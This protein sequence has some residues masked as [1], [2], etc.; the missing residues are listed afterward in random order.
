M[1]SADAILVDRLIPATFLEDL[2]VSSAGKLVQW[3][4]SEEPHWTQEEVNRWLVATAKT[5]RTVARL[6]GGDPFVFGR[7]DSEIE[8]LASH[9]IPWEVIPGASSAT[10][11]LGSAGLP[12]TRHGQRRSF[13]VATARVEGG[14]VSTSFPPRRLAGDSDGGDGFGPS[15]GAAIGRWLAVRHARGGC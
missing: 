13:A 2:G 3:L 9:R 8:S 12:L 4:G 7:G 11:V 14:Q 15:D 10:A 1:R 5:G 6:K